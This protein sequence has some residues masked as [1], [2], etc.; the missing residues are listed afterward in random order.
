[1][2]YTSALRDQRRKK[3]SMGK[4]LKSWPFRIGALM[5]AGLVL[6]GTAFALLPRT[7][8]RVAVTVVQCATVSP[9]F[10]DECPGTTIFHRSFS[11]EATV[12]ALRNVLDGMHYFGLFD[13]VNCNG[14]WETTRVYSV[15]LLWHGIVVK[16]YVAPVEQ[17]GGRCWWDVMTLGVWQTA[18]EGTTTWAELVRL[19]G[20]PVIPTP[21]P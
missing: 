12:S 3:M 9:L 13:N 14:G 16:R 6:Y 2:G 19:T 20:M 5:L 11:R 8:D 7:A 17:L 18:T 10:L 4:A 1:V 21:E 15:D